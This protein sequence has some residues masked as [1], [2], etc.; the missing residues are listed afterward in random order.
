MKIWRKFSHLTKSIKTLQ[1]REKN[2]KEIL[3]PFLF[4]TKPKNNDSCIT[5]CKK[6]DVCKNFLITDNTFNCKVTG[7]FYNVRGK[8][9]CNSSNVIYLI[10]CKNCEDQYI[11]SAIDFN[12]RFRIHRSDKKPKKDR[13]GSARHFNT[14]PTRQQDVVA[15]L[16]RRRN[17]VSLYVS[18]TSQ[19][20]LKWNTQRR[21]SGTSPRRLSG[22]FSR[23]LIGMPWWRLMGT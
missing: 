23:S 7:R 2:L 1:R 9:S 20:R 10:S 5:S 8:L 17:D 18:V 3:S 6:C 14:K 12:V 13:C 21:L 4:P 15:T 19:V 16:W 11:G 22:T